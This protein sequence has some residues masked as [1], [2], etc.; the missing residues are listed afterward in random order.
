M[1]HSVSPRIKAEKDEVDHVIH[2][3]H[4]V[5]DFEVRADD[6]LSMIARD[7]HISKAQALEVVK[8]ELLHRPQPQSAKD[9]RRSN[10]KGNGREE[11]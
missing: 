4:R 5:T 3:Y 11:L 1:M 10:Y 9:R 6:A 8:R 2:Y 7:H